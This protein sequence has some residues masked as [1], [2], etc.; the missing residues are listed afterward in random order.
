ARFERAGDSGKHAAG[1]FGKRSGKVDLLLSRRSCHLQIGRSKLLFKVLRQH[2]CGARTFLHGR[3][4]DLYQGRPAKGFNTKKAAA[5]LS[6]RL[7]LERAWVDAG[8]Y[9]GTG[10]GPFTGRS[11]GLEHKSV[12]GIE[13]NGA[14][15][16]HRR[17]LSL[18]W[19]SQVGEVNVSNSACRSG[20]FAPRHCTRR[21]PF[22]A[23]AA[24]A[25]FSTTS[26]S[27]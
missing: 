3:L 17:R 10:H 5:E 2:L 7:A 9:K 20:F 18:S 11:G 14:Q 24:E 27:T 21:S 19:S 6:S 15:C 25:P 1:V 4:N 13:A 23:I 22:S 26:R 16:L 12:G 8:E